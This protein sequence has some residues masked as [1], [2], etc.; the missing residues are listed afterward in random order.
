MRHSFTAVLSRNERHSGDFET[1]P[2]EVGWATEARLFVNVLDVS[3]DDPRWV[4]RIE[5]SPDGLHWCQLD[6]QTLVAEEPRLYTMAF[7]EFGNWIRVRGSC[8]AGGSTL[9]SIISVAL[10]E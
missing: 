1:E 9:R 8:E 4:F 2:Y 7:R 5:I 6:A 10:K 3:G